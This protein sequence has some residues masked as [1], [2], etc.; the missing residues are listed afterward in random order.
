MQ[1][2][3]QFCRPARPLQSALYNRPISLGGTTMTRIT[4]LRVFDLRF[5]TSQSLDGSDAMNPDPDYSAAYVILGTDRAGLE[6][7]GL[8]FTIGRGNEICCA[9]IEAM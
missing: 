5:P 4:D 7:H 2:A 8:T 1:P 3:R 6:G 9:A